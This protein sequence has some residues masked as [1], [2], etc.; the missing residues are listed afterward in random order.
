MRDTNREILDQ[1]FR[2][3][4]GLPD[5][6]DVRAIRLVDQP[7]WDSLKHVSLVLAVESEF[8]LSIDIADSV[9]LTSYEAFEGFLEE[10][11]L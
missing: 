4:L 3:V 10:K 9:D 11:G 7:G 2:A 1:V 5:D 8:N 6:A